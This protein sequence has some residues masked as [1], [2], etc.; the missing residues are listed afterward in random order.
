MPFL[1]TLKSLL[2]TLDK[3]LLGLD[4][5]VKK[6][7]INLASKDAYNHVVAVVV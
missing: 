3:L 1:G 7:K 2:E 6:S 4:T 5:N